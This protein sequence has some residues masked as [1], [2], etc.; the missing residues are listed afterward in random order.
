MSAQFSLQEAEKDVAAARG[1]IVQSPEK[2]VA[3]VEQLRSQVQRER[4]EA[5]A[6]QAEAATLA[7]SVP[8]LAAIHDSVRTVAGV[9][10][11]AAA[12][13]EQLAA[14]H[15]QAEADSRKL[16]SLT[17]VL[18][19]LQVENTQVAG[20]IAAARKKEDRTRKTLEGKLREAE[21]RR[22]GSEAK[23]GRA[24]DAHNK[25]QARI[26]EA[27]AMAAKLDAKRDAVN[28]AHRRAM[29]GLAGKYKD[30]E[31]QV[32]EYHASVAKAAATM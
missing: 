5:T 31:N 7:A 30:L 15:T 10:A 1:K 12:E 13:G 26:A 9:V 19:E 29:D 3:A 21:E 24:R 28:A 11:E 6:K 23:L 17:A 2:F 14:L 20:A 4:D 18:G 25:R 32:A 8:P 16:H 27:D 22:L